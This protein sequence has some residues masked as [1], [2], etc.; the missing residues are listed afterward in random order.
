MASAIEKGLAKLHMAMNM[1]FNM[2]KIVPWGLPH[3]QAQREGFGILLSELLVKWLKAV[4]A[5][6]DGNSVIPNS[7]HRAQCRASQ[8]RSVVVHGGNI[9]VDT[10]C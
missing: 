2:I 1:H 9:L 7:I 6:K 4:W 10:E 8:K 5:S 3:Y